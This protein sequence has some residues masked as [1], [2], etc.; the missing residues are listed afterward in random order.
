MVLRR[1]SP[2]VCAVGDRIAVLTMDQA[3][4]LR[5]YLADV[6]GVRVPA[7][8]PQTIDRLEE[9]LPPPVDP[10]AEVDVILEAVDAL[11]RISVLKAIRELT[12]V[13]LKEARD[14]IESVPS[15]V[16]ADL[17][18]AEAVRFKTQLEAA[19]ARVVLR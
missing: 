12:L 15:R 5:D 19:G 2:D 10:S 3:R 14:L 1:W 7:A 18:P 4:E 9:D 16:A 6:H 17:S 13:G 11:R 8:L